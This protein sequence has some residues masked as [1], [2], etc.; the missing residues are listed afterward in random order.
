MKL[1]DVQDLVMSFGGLR[2]LNRV[3]FSVDEGQIVS[4]IGPNGAGKTTVF[5]LLT[6][7]YLPVS[8][9]A[10]FRE[11]NILGEKSW[12][13]AQLGISRTFQNIRLFASLTAVENVRIGLTSR[14]KYSV[15]AA[16]S[17]SPGCRRVEDRLENR[18]REIL[19]LVGLENRGDTNSANL[20]YGQ[21]RRLELAR[22]LALDPK[23]LLLD[24]PSAGM[25]PMETSELMETIRGFR[26]QGI[27]IL[28]VEHDMKMVMGIS[29]QVVV[30]DNGIKI[31]EGAPEE[32]KADPAVIKAY[33]GEEAV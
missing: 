19:S 12:K 22:A 2:A 20:T 11:R 23:L 3:G 17:G 18:A 5:N 4:L 28:L 27:T 33:L 13:I 24:E 8:G 10:L 6:G 26:D 32:I 31:A 21:Q 25:P 9:R 29:D 14:V 30:L 16:L 7:I 15:L 1:L